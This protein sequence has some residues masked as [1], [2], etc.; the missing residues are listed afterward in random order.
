M[1]KQIQAEKG[2][3][4]LED[5]ITSLDVRKKDLIDR[6]SELENKKKAIEN[7]ITERKDKEKNR[8]SEEIKFLEFQ[9]TNLKKFVATLGAS[10]KI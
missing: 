2:K 9:M 8:R 4:D 10:D 5:R 7:R 1:R 3:K 6:K